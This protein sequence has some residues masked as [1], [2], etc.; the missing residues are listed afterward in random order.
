MCS[1]Q[2][3]REG[4]LQL[5]PVESELPGDIKAEMIGR[6][7]EMDTWNPRSQAQGGYV[8]VSHRSK[9]S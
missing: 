9:D 6:Q 3:R 1:A 7:L 5:R 2:G 4:D 8:I